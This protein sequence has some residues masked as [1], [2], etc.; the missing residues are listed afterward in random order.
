MIVSLEPWEYEWA[1]MVGVRRFTAN[2]KKHDKSYYDRSRMMDDRTAAVASAITELAVAKATNRYWSGSVWNGSDHDKYKSTID[3]GRNIE[4]RMARGETVAVRPAQLGKGLVLFG[5]CPI[6]PEFKQVDVWGW[7]NYDEAWHLA[8]E[9][10]G[11]DFRRIHKSQ[12]IQIGD[13]Q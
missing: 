8:S 3:V 2:W 6:G 13:F 11:K 9:V 10:E 4:V 5:G 7:R 1:A 12:L